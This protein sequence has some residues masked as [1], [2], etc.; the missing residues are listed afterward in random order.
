MHNDPRLPSHKCY[1]VLVKKSIQTDEGGNRNWIERCKCGRIVEIALKRR[2]N[3]KKVESQM[4]KCWRDR[5]GKLIK[6]T[7]DVD[8]ISNDTKQVDNSTNENCVKD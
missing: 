5:D 6:T 4:V 7:G 2:E 1:Y 3:S 8:I